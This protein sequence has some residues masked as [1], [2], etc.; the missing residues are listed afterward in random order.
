MALPAPR[1]GVATAAAEGCDHAHPIAKISNLMSPE[2][3]VIVGAGQGGLQVAASLRE[4][5]FGGRVL[6]IGDE[7]GLPY[8]RP[9]LSKAYLAGEMALDR[10]WLRSAAFLAEHGIDLLAAERVVAV[11]RVAAR[12][13][14][15]SGACHAYDHLGLATGSR[16]RSLVVE[17]ADL[18]GVMSLRTLA[19]ADAL[20]PRLGAV[21]EVVIV[22]AGFIGLEFASVAC[23]LGAR[24]H[25]VELAQRPMA[26]A[27]SPQISEHFHQVHAGRGASILFSTSVQR[28]VG[29]AGRVTAVETSDGLTIPAELVLIGVGVVPNVE[30]AEAA[31]LEVENGIVVDE[32]LLTGDPAIS[33]LGDCAAFPSRHAGRRVRLESVQ[34]A[35]DQGR[36]I[37]ARLAG[38]AAAY[39]AVPWFWSDQGDLRLQIVG[40]TAG[41]DIAVTRGE[42]ASGR[43]SV[44]CFK[45]QRLLGIESVNRPA[46]HMAGRRLLAGEIPVS[47]DEAANESFDLKAHIAK[48]EPSRGS[49]GGR[50]G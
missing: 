16:D 41:H 42:V 34:N 12:V 19:D 14:L 9:P 8:Q 27:V 47:P 35:V 3:V 1:R 50:S 39:R 20:R 44:F 40:L 21:E 15:G 32:H 11:D 43:F 37:A 46:D 45:G 33:A 2:R 29:C 24:V 13:R 5:G 17:G 36:C 23:K 48:H 10:L 7:P 22:G 25:V 38:R 31:G 4:N 28:I 6:L 18:D 49:G 26:R 30:L